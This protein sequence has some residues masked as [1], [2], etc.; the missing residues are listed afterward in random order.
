MPIARKFLDWNRPALHAAA[1]WL[2]A[3]YRTENLLDMQHALVVV[4]GKRA[5]R[6]LLELLVE[7][8]ERIDLPFSPPQLVTPDSLP[9][10]LYVPKRPFANELTLRWAWVKA[11]QQTPRD[12]LRPL[13]PHA[14]EPHDTPRWLQLGAVLSKLHVE[15]A[16]DALN[17]AAVR[18]SANTIDGF[19]EDERWQA[20]EA[21]QTVYLQTLDALNL[22]DVQTAR[23]VAIE[24]HEVAT[25]REI[26]L[27]GMADL[28]RAHRLMLQQ[29]AERVTALVFAPP[30]LA[31]RFDE[32]G[33]LEP[34]AWVQA[35]VPISDEHY[36]RVDGPAD[37]AEEVTSWLAALN[38][39]YRADEI[40]VVLPDEGLAPQLE[41]QLAQCGL[42]AHWQGAQPVA[43]TGPVQLLQLAAEY[44]TH[45]RFRDLAALA[46]HPDVG[47]WLEGRLAGALAGVDPLSLLDEYASTRLPAQI[48]EDRLAKEAELQGVKAVTDALRAL[49]QPLIHEPQT[50]DAWAGAMRQV[51]TNVYGQL[52]LDKQSERDRKLIESLDAISASLDELA[53][54]PLEVQQPLDA[55]SAW[56]TALEGLAKSTLS[57]PPD[58]TAVE[59]IGWLD[60]P[61]DDAPAAIVTTFNDG[62]VPTSAHAHAFL[63]NRL[64]QQLGMQHNDRRLARDAYAV[65]L[66]ISSRPQVR[67]VVTHRDVDRNP[68]IPS[69]LL[70]ACS[71]EQVVQRAKL[72]F[73]DLPRGGQRRS[74]LTPPA[75][76]R[77]KSLLQ[78]PQ[79]QRLPSPLTA[80]SVTRFRDYLACPYRFYLRHVLRLETA[81][82]SAA[83]LDG[84]E[85]G[86]LVHSILEQF[87]KNPEAA[88]LRITE[89]P[90]PI[91][92]YLEHELDRFSAAR[93]G[94]HPRP[95]VRVQLEQLRMRLRAFAEWQAARARGGWRIVHAEDSGPRSRRLETPLLVDGQPF[96]ITGRI[97]RID[98]HERLHKLAVLD[99]KTSD[100]GDWPRDT[101][102]KRDEWVDL[103]L[104]LYRHLLKAARLPPAIA[105][106]ESIELGYI[107]LPKELSAIGLALADWDAGE[108]AAADAEAVRVIRALREQKFWP[109]AD[110]PPPFGDELSALCQDRRLGAA[111][112]HAEEEGAA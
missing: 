109:P 47:D 22:W 40:S 29:V 7:G 35:D 11:L 46:R 50:L 65:S 84:S 4:P 61:L 73:G 86:N 59:L 52:L 6:R 54:V 102:C 106:C 10:Q 79:P 101:H 33:C 51:L 62:F 23:L 1:E 25:E 72:F 68:L 77:P 9:E 37:Q 97:D 32:L 81:V 78:R 28:P 110:K 21:L 93:Y 83:E 55:R 42:R 36:R 41:R 64:Q 67:L 105:A 89:Q 103:Q 57:A 18:Q 63:P 26:V 82:D 2:I 87:G 80:L 27:V 58:P 14:P 19:A 66:L 45:H 43:G 107:L 34:A 24:R 111:F 98:Y 60:A 112:L 17:C 49:V 76:P 94:K 90:Q 39:R 30:D 75:G 56:R 38:G 95:A 44:A 13:L 92:E 69:R 16:A 74:R 12:R 48:D 99:Y 3:R 5:G 88:D 53:D 31:T 85:F 70:F 20:L 91:V 104:P 100:R 15:L 108:L 8:G 96:T 71:A